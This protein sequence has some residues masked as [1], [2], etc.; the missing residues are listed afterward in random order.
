MD[1]VFFY[2]H[3]CAFKKIF[4]KFHDKMFNR[5]LENKVFKS[6]RLSIKVKFSSFI[7]YFVLQPQ[8]HV[9]VNRDCHS[10]DAFFHCV[11]MFL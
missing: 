1:Q 8:V 2:N 11:Y 5:F 10:L 4:N 7:S 6:I 3:E 9:H